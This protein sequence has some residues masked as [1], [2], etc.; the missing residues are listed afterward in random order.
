MTVS[1][2]FHSLHSGYQA[3]IDD[4]ILKSNGANVL[5]QRFAQ[6]CLELKFLLNMILFTPEMGAVILLHAMKLKSATDILNLFSH[7]SDVLPEWGNS[8]LRFNP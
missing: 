7:D 8:C 6:R 1:I 4:L 5:H 2:F 3:E